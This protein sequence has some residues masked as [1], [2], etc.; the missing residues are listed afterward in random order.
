MCSYVDSVS[1]QVCIWLFGQVLTAAE[2]LPAERSGLQIAVEAYKHELP[3]KLQTVFKHFMDPGYKS[4]LLTHAKA[5]AISTSLLLLHL[6][7]DTCYYHI[8][9]LLCAHSFG[10]AKDCEG[11]SGSR[12]YQK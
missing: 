8:F 5:R 10:H 1:F 11:H 7:T 6:N 3:E 4:C 9:T 2:G 12:S